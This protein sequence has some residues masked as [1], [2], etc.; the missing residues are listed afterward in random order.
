MKQSKPA[1]SG[2]IEPPRLLKADPFSASKRSRMQPCRLLVQST[3]RS[4][5]EK[6]PFLLW[7][8]KNHF[9]TTPTLFLKR[10]ERKRMLEPLPDRATKNLTASKE[11]QTI[12]LDVEE[13]ESN[14][15]C[16]RKA[17]QAAHRLKEISAATTRCSGWAM[18]QKT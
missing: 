6:E 5:N 12:L 14:M 3:D 8:R 9:L 11:K 1:P 10:E 16:S 2:G 15:T 18:E 7:A 4:T 13:E 17:I